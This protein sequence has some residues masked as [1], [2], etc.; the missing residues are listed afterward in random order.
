MDICAAT[1]THSQNNP[2]PELRSASSSPA[3]KR[4]AS[5]NSSA[6]SGINA[7]NLIALQSLLLNRIKQNLVEA[8]C[9]ATK[10]E[11]LSGKPVHELVRRYVQAVRDLQFLQEL[12]SNTTIDSQHLLTLALPTDYNDEAPKPTFCGLTPNRQYHRYSLSLNAASYSLAG[13]TMVLAPMFVM[14]EVPGK[15]ATLYTAA[16]FIIAFTVAMVCFR[17]FEPRDTVSIVAAY[18]AVLVTFVGANTAPEVHE[19]A[20]ARNGTSMANG[21]AV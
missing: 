5:V 2:G 11:N 19:R 15:E 14:V 20:M 4:P 21:T 12:D 13:V 17:H 18:T 1:P 16:A 8:L 7:I 6:N 9:N 10:E 3:K